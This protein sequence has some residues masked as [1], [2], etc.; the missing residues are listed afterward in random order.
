MN[1]V[2]FVRAGRGVSSTPAESEFREAV[3]RVT[4]TR[5]PYLS[6]SAAGELLGVHRDTVRQACA[7]GEIKCRRRGDRGRYRIHVDDLMTYW[8]EYRPWE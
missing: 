4:G 1:N 2:S 8:S 5:S 3:F 6:T 7:R